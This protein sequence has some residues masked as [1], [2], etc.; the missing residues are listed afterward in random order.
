MLHWQNIGLGRYSNAGRGS[1]NL[2]AD[3]VQVPASAGEDG[4]YYKRVN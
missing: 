4:N 3:Y 1:R 2:S